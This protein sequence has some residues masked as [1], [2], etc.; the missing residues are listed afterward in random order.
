MVATHITSHPAS[1]QLQSQQPSIRQPKK[2]QEKSPDQQLSTQQ[3]QRQLPNTLHQNLPQI[4][5]QKRKQPLN[6][7]TSS[8][9]PTTQSMSPTRAP[10]TAH[11]TVHTMLERGT[12]ASITRIALLVSA[13][14]SI[15]ADASTMS[16]I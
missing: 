12:M 4:I 11:N 9:S 3:Q 1:N 16:T 14:L 5:Q 13:T 2:Q 6:H 15:W 7:M 10:L 8:G